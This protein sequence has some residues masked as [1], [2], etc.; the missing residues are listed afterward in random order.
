MACT[1]I[2]RRSFLEE[3][4]LR[5]VGLREGAMLVVERETVL[6]KGRTAARV[7]EKGRPAVESLPG[8]HLDYLLG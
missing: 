4:D 7:F 1:K 2:A 8:E 3:N 6:L 5:V